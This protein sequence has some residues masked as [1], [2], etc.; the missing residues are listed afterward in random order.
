VFG[1]DERA[2][3]ARPRPAMQG[4]L[5]AK[6]CPLSAH[7]RSAASASAATR[8]TQPAGWAKSGSPSRRLPG[9]SATWTATTAR[10]S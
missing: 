2:T 5:Q 1:V 3:Q 10:S 8:Y 6:A 9:R 4:H 7:P